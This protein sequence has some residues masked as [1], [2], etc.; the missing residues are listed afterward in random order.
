VPWSS[1]EAHA[2]LCTQVD[3]DYRRQVRKAYYLGREDFAVGSDGTLAYNNYLEE[4]EDMVRSIFRRPMSSRKA[5][6]RNVDRPALSFAGGSLG[7]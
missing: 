2:I 4:F 1:A 5:C 6:A 7:Q 3:R